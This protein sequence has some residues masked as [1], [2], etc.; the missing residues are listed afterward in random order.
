MIFDDGGRILLVRATGDTTWDLPGGFLLAGEPPEDGLA[1]EL[2]EE[3]SI[4]ILPVQI[5]AAIVDGYGQ[6]E[7]SLNLFYTARVLSG[8]CR[9]RAEI[10]EACYW[11]LDDLPV[12]K[13]RSTAIALR[14][15]HGS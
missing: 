4:E 13:Y 9:P 8:E 7:W 5:L 10:E 6:D 2:R 12:L 3:L 1:R 14:K 15:V 11:R